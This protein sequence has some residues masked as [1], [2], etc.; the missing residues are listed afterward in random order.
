MVELKNIDFYKNPDDNWKEEKINGVI[1]NVP[2]NFNCYKLSKHHSF[3][4]GVQIEEK[5]QL[6]E[7]AEG[8]I[9][10]LYNIDFKHD[11]NLRFIE[12]KY[13]H[14]IIEIDDIVITNVG[15]NAG[16]VLT[17]KY[18]V[19]CNN[20]FKININEEQLIKKYLY[21]IL[22]S[23]LYKNQLN[24]LFNSN[25][26][27]HIGHKNMGNIVIF[28]SSLEEQ[29]KIASILETQENL[30]ISKKEL[31][32]KYKK[33]RK[34]FQQ[35]LLSGRIR[36]KLNNKS[37]AEAF[38]LG[39]IKQTFL[40]D[41]NEVVEYGGDTIT[42]V[43]IDI[44]DKDGFE[45]WLSIDFE[46]KIEFYKNID[47]KEEKINGRNINIPNDWMITTIKDYNEIP[48][49]KNCKLNS[50]N[51][52]ELG[53]LKNNKIYF[54]DKLTVSGAKEF[55]G[56]NLILI[57]TVRPNSNS[58]ALLNIKANISN[59]FATIIPKSK[60]TYYVTLKKSFY[61]DMLKLV[62]GTTYPVIKK[63][64]I[65]NMSYELPNNVIEQSLIGEQLTKID[66]LIESLEEEIK[67]EDKKF[68]Y[69]K[70]ELLSGRIRVN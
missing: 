15:N 22:K 24:K 36:M 34:Y 57:G 61:Y 26:K 44:I 38:E 62:E 23:S 4:Q 6:R 30:I 54:K 27:P 10:Y 55:N 3:M 14:K 48:N 28:H 12:N 50:N 5:N 64:F 20:A 49:L 51:Y 17:G 31:L 67:L 69:L 2:F 11:N 1:L 46:N 29:E 18:G 43:N 25:G 68:T 53:D 58:I 41:A 21:F 16:E 33:Q 9:R 7:I 19:L 32:E 52:I 45:S 35:E 66:N 63:D 56:D 60:F 47:F 8:Y 40:N 59:A 42:N 39:L 37:M 65:Y 70:Q 13:N